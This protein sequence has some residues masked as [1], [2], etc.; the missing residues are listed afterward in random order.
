MPDKM[1]ILQR[2]QAGEITAQE[3]LEL[4]NQGESPTPQAPP[5]AASHKDPAPNN[6]RHSDPVQNHP[7]HY[8]EYYDHDEFDHHHEPGWADGLFGWVG[9][10]VNDI[11]SEFKDWDISA[12]ISDL[13]GGRYSHNK[14]TERFTSK[15]ILQSLALLE[16]HGKN[17]K[18]EIQGYDGD[19]VQIECFYDARY[20]DAY[21]Q[22]H[23]EDGAVSLL[24]DDK[25]MRSVQVLCRVPRMHIGQLIAATKND[26]IRLIEVSAG[27][28]NLSTKNASIYMEA[29]NSTNLT[30]N[31]RNDN[32]KA[33]AVTGSHIHFETTNSKI[34]VE[35]IHAK[36]LELITTNAGIKTAGIDAINLYMKTTNTGLKLEDTLH[37]GNSPFWDEE[38]SIEAYTT[39]GG[40]KLFLPEGIGMK[41]E[42][43]AS[44]GKVN[45][46]IPLYNTEGNRSYMVG[47]SV[48]Y[49]S[50]GRRLNTRLHTTNA[51]IRIRGM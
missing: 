40:I 28:I 34:S 15:P 21:V 44:G 47:E 10:V 19:T 9:E 45:C 23:D 29:I 3:A 42:A 24:F 25:I 20:P 30:A 41:V 51:N 1:T 35:D 39:N 5:Q 43:N 33:R 49:A 4:M 18:I 46:D 8:P 36:T 38:R 12:N 2:L 37:G 16:L 22:F 17:D 26:R 32:I 50:S 11:T 7:N 6:P 27:D 13:V 14:R 48:S 31:T